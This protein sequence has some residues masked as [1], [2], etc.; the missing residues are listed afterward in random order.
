MW[1]VA[2]IVI[3]ALLLAVATA[4]KPNVEN[5]RAAA[6]GDFQV[7]RAKYGDPKGLLWGTVR[8]KSPVCVWVGDYTPVPIKTKVPDGL[9]SS[10][11]VITGYKYHVG[12]DLSWCLGGKAGQTV[13]LKKLWAGKKLIFSGNLTTDS[14]ITINLPLLFGGDK[15]RGGLL[16]DITFYT[17]GFSPAQ[18]PYLISKLGAN[19]PAYNGVAR[20]VFKG[21][22]A[23]NP[24]ATGFYFGTSPNIESLNA[25]LS[26]MSNNLH[27]TYSIMPN[28][29]DVNPMEIM[30]DAVTER[31]GRFGASQEDIDLTTWQAAAQTLYNEGLGMSLFLQSAINGRQLAEEVLRMADGLLY[32]DPST[33]KIVVKLTR[34]DYDVATLETL[35]ESMVEELVSFE[36]TTWE[37]T[38]NQCRINYKDRTQDYNESVA[39]AHDFAL[40]NYQ[41]RVKSTDLSMIGCYDKNVANMLAARQLS[42]VSVPLFKLELVCNRKASNLRPGMVRKFNWGPYGLT[43]LVIRI[44]KVDL[45]TLEDGKVRI[46]CIQD[47]FST[48]TQVF[49]PPDGSAWTP[50]NTAAAPVATRRM[51]EPP[52]FV[53]RNAT[54]TGTVPTGQSAVYVLANAPGPASVS[55]DAQISTDNFATLTTALENAVYNG[56][57]TLLAAFLA[58]NHTNGFSATGFTATGVSGGDDLASFGSLSEIRDGRSL[59]MVDNELM[60]FRTVTNAGSDKVFTN[61]YR[62]LLGTAI[63]DHAAGARVWFIQDVDGLLPALYTGG[64]KIRL[65]DYTPANQLDPTAAPQD[66]LAFTQV[67]DKPLPPRYLTINGSRTPAKQWAGGTVTIGWRESNR[68]ASTLTVYDDATQTP[69]APTAYRIRWRINGGSWNGPVTTAA[70]AV[71]HVFDITGLAGLLEFEVKAYLNTVESTV[72]DIL[73]IDVD[74]TELLLNGAMATDTVWTKGPGWTIASGKATHVGP[75]AGNLEQPIAFVAGATYRVVFTVLDYTAGDVTARFIGGTAV[76]GTPRTA[77]GTYSQDL[78][79]Q[80]GNVDFKFLGQTTFAG[81][82]D[83]AS[84]KRVG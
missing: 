46:V 62:G 57:G 78:V 38:L 7:P 66:T 27:A 50:P 13:K 72:G 9:F 56:S 2:I 1:V 18:D 8:A 82:V 55:Y 16:G 74:D 65:I 20:T 53:A 45:G 39:V 52:Y 40:I 77:N 32:Q 14:T 29:L 44:L 28:G 48:Q 17:G 25:E 23:L 4:P 12:M 26:R 19:V 5:A 34:F 73:G 76:S 10:K 70:A 37:A 49:A 80:T 67:A 68:L 33:A 60:A 11:K 61:V 24:K 69:E 36:K 22:A 6:F 81:A 79:A 51:W 71:S 59:L 15:E 43:A 21:N 42:F 35:D 83:N 64:P 84:L 31:W 3:I 41:Q 58:T 30:Y 54:S 75:T 47:R 63:A